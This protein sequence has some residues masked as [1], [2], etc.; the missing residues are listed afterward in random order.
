MREGMANRPIGRDAELL[1]IDGFLVAA[2]HGPAGLVLEGPAGIGKSTLAEAA[3][4]EAR[5]RGFRVLSAR[6]SGAEAAWAYQSLADLLA[7]AGDDALASLPPP[8][9]QAIDVALLRKTAPT[10][11]PADAPAQ[12][13]AISVGAVNAIISLSRAG[14]V[15]LVIDDA[16][17]LDSATTAVLAFVARR[18]GTHP[19]GMLVTQRVDEPGPAPLELDGVI[20]TQRSW[21]APLSVGALH[22]LLRE[23]L[24]LTLPRSTLA[25]LREMARGNPFHALEIGRALQ[26]LPALPKPGEPLPIPSS[27][28]GLMQ[29]HL[30]TVS[31][32]TRETLLVAAAAGSPSVDELRRAV[33]PAADTAMEEA[34]DA[35]LLAVERGFARF[36]HPSLAQAVYED[37]T[38][39]ARRL[40]HAALA[41]AVGEAEA[42]GRHLALATVVPD[43][44]VAAALEEA[45]IDAKRRG[46]AETA[47][48]LCRL[49]VDRTPPD[50]VPG[51]QRRSLLLANLLTELPDLPAAE[52]IVRD[53]IRTLPPEPARAEARMLAGTIAWYTQQNPGLAAVTHV[54]A[55]L[56]DA[57]SDPVLLGRMHYH[58]SVFYD[59]DVR[60]AAR[61]ASA[62][63]EILA[64]RDA[65]ITQAAAMFELFATTVALGK[66]APLDLLDE[67]LAIEAGGFHVDQSTVPGIWW[68]AID[69][70]D[71][72][73]SRFQAMLDGSRAAGETSGEA[74]LLTRLAETELY[75]DRW[76]LALQ[77]ADE[78]TI[79]AHQE[80]QVTADPARRIRAL[81]EAHQGR[82]EEARRAATEGLQ[83]AEEAGDWLIASSYLLVLG[84][85]ASSEGKP[86]EVERF[87]ERSARHLGAIGRVQP[88]RLDLTPERIEALVAL[89]R[90]D[91]AEANLESF[92]EGA[93]ILP[94][95]W[96]E[97]V[98]ARGSGRLLAARGH[99]E[100]AVAATDPAMD[101]RSSSWRSFDRARTQFVRGELLRQMR[102]RRDAGD[103]LERALR[104]FEALGAVVWAERARA[105]LDRLGRHRPGT[106]DLT[107]TE[108]RVAELAA[109]G[110][111][112]REVAEALG[113]SAKTV[114]AHLAHIYAK[115]AIRSRAELGRAFR[116]KTGGPP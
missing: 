93:R 14:P 92:T 46:A 113:I 110:M 64:D 95:P 73:R 11:T 27:L 42:R 32:A 115:L 48:E 87:A 10:P 47:T 20:P 3:I 84:L 72:A 69:R 30:A 75:A 70:P 2:S 65:P 5:R 28:R 50:D 21:L 55:G 59:F 26:R 74:D 22:L 38:P 79:V 61:H 57:V 106:E 66:P 111:R 4:E 103:V 77:L 88:L 109:S 60:A 41:D 43:S 62:A 63:R 101:S 35:G 52:T 17:W 37:A 24:E 58:L 12:A 39:A 85:V 76:D 40:A 7:G 1:V 83:R 114:E 33:G 89:R 19:I 18:L 49:A 94:R 68:I 13:R 29:G 25:R 86:A 81:I 53:L 108:R 82:V 102:S 97:A 36:S 44:A 99:L 80:G 23:R 90:L 91:E 78:A 96:A 107:P 8:Q 67:A 56:P 54:E 105:E 51:R 100:E 45:A 16:P 34:I 9:R 15:L 116:Q 31:D 98:I 6:P 71:L 104:S 112:N